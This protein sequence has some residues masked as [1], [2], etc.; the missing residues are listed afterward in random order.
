[1]L[2]GVALIKRSDLKPIIA[3]NGD[4]QNYARLAKKLGIK[5]NV[6]FLGLVKDIERIYALADIFILPTLCDPAEMSPLEAM[7]L[8]DARIISYSKYANIAEQILNN[9]ALL[10]E[11]PNNPQ[12]IALS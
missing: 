2:K 1:M 12:A 11:N 3:D 7:A 4:Q 5:E 6:I 8:G 10:L 9:D